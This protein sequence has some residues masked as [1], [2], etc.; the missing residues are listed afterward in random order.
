[1][2][3]WYRIL[4]ISSL[5]RA[6]TADLPMYS[7]SIAFIDI[8]RRTESECCYVHASAARLNL[9]DKLPERPSTSM[10]R[11]HRATAGQNGCMQCAKQ[12][13]TQ[14]CCHASHVDRIRPG[15]KAPRLLPPGYC[16]SMFRVFCLFACTWRSRVVA[17]DGNETCPICVSQVVRHSLP[18]WSKLPPHAPSSTNALPA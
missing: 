13:R 16:L 6:K 4:S 11:M 1:M 14:S 15:S 17:L 12:I 18:F 8:H 10:G 7:H 9:K 2:H 5:V 3:A